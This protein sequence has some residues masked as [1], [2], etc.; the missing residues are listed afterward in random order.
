[1][2]D[3]NTFTY[4][5]NWILMGGT[6]N[7]KFLVDSALESRF[8]IMTPEKKLD[9]SLTKHIHRSKKFFIDDEV[10][11]ALRDELINKWNICD[12][13]PILPDE[14]Y[15]PEVNMS[16]RE[17]SGL[18]SKLMCKKWWGITMSNDEIIEEA[19]RIKSSSENVWRSEED[20]V[21]DCIFY[22]SKTVPEISKLLGMS[23]RNVR[24]HL[25][26]IRAI[27]SIEG[28]EHTY[29]VY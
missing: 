19:K 3:D 21:F 13:K 4:K 16:I 18:L 25:R 7:K 10:K 5:T 1:F 24:K 6:Y 11:F 20:K 9:G 12:Y 8:V 17:A 22:E 26:S 14:V 28:G 15:S 27:H 2:D 23:S 29:R